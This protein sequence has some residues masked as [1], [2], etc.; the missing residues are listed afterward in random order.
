MRVTL[1]NH[2]HNPTLESGRGIDRYS[3]YLS[4]GL[5]SRNIFVKNINAVNSKNFIIRNLISV[6]LKAMEL[7]YE[8][9]DLYHS[10]TPDGAMLSILQ[11]KHPVITNI[12]DVIP[13]YDSITDRGP[14]RNVYSKMYTKIV[15]YVIQ[16]SIHLIVP[17]NFTKYWLVENLFIDDSKVSVINYGID[18]NLNNK[19]MSLSNHFCKD[20]GNY[21][22]FIGGGRPIFRGLPFV[23]KS[24][25]KIAMD[26]DD[27]L[28]ISLQKNFGG[29]NQYNEAL[30]IIRKY[31]LGARVKII[32]FIPE[33]LLPSVLRESRAL[34]FP[35]KMGFSF[36]ELQAMAVGTPVIATNC[37]DN[38]EFLKDS[39][40]MCPDGDVD[41]FSKAIFQLS[42]D[43]NL[44][45][46]KSYESI[47]RSKLFSVE[48]M[49]EST[50]QLYYSF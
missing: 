20:I 28:V 42:N 34:L 38:A 4:N 44:H 43:K 6:P 50:I 49:L 29:Q 41:C 17:F 1:V 31:N 30:R 24:F 37:Y 27:H 13:F 36:L 19:N 26:I 14:L 46:L 5:I 33:R 10:I 48:R 21:Y 15:R 47:K 9:S 18:F 7:F 22:I 45:A 39:G 32:D 3:Y 8:K 35:S 23:L 2:P 25:S 16:N 12:H 40:V 11:H